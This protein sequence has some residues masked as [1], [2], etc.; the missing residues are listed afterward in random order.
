MLLYAAAH[1]LSLYFHSFYFSFSHGNGLH[2]KSGSHTLHY[3]L[4]R[5]AHHIMHQPEVYGC[6]AGLAPMR[7]AGLVNQL[8]DYGTC[9]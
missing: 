7:R 5:M 8:Q 2:N 3:L 1:C 6:T 9:L 4:D